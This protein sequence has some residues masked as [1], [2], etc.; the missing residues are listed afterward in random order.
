MEREHAKRQRL[1]GF[2]KTLPAA[3]TAVAALAAHARRES[4]G[5]AVA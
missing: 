3:P 2:C 5:K 1:I 4:A